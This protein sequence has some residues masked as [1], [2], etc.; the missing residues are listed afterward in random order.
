MA[1]T[2][3]SSS[4]KAP[5]KKPMVVKKSQY[6]LERDARIKRNEEWMI[7]H[8]FNPYGSGP[9]KEIKK[10]APRPR[11]PK[12]YVPE[13]ER[14]RSPRLAGETIAPKRLTYDGSDDERPKRRS[15][16]SRR[17]RVRVVDDLSDEQRAALPEGFTMDAFIESPV[18]KELS[19]QNRRSVI[20]QVRKL[21]G[22]GRD[23]RLLAGG[24]SL[25]QRR[26]GDH[27]IG[28]L[29]DHRRRQGL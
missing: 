22:R 28:H 12:R 20:R 4:A 25:P 26:A 27:A 19:E 1:P 21:V 7:A 3:K 13:S 8:G 2:K 6:E 18:I 14:R 10:K 5:A 29:G 17:W 11:A 16:S 9:L 15:Q 23:L 24:R